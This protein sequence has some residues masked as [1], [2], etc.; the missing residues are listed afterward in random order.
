[1]NLNNRYKL[2][3][4]NSVKFSEAKSQQIFANS[5]WRLLQ[6]KDNIILVIFVVFLL[7]F[8]FS[9]VHVC[10]KITSVHGWSSACVADWRTERWMARHTPDQCCTLT[11]E[12][13]G[14]QPTVSVVLCM[15]QSVCT[16]AK[17]SWVRSVRKP[18]SAV[19]HTNH[20]FFA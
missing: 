5:P 17:L 6:I 1:M 13:G 9:F 15:D 11:A 3:Q 4:R 8:L 7:R 10:L 16:R 19:L 2:L 14:H 12:C 18:Q 20:R